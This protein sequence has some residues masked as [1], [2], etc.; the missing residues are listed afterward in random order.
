MGKKEAKKTKQKEQHLNNV[1]ITR[2][3]SHE[4]GV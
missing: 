2:R 3:K 4:F 1:N